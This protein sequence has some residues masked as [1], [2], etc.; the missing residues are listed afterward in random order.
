M[1]GG[2]ISEGETIIDSTLCC[3]PAAATSDAAASKC[4]LLAAINLVCGI[5]WKVLRYGRQGW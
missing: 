5:I 4:T 3:L 2:V 1:S